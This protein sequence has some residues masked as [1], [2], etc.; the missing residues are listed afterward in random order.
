MPLVVETGAGVAG[1]DAYV[2]V[3][4]ADTYHADRSNATWAAAT[5]PEKEA[6]IRV[7]TQYIDGAYYAR[8]KGS[9]IN[10]LQARQWPRWGVQLEHTR[11][12]SSAQYDGGFLPGLFP[13]NIIPEQLKQAVCELAL[14]A[15]SG[16]LAADLKRGGRVASV[17][18]GP[19]ETSYEAGAPAA[20]VYQTVDQLLAP[21]IA[22][23][24]QTSLVRG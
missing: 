21:F 18:V 3:A 12:V 23:A 9:I 7:A 11:S 5:Q 13:S 20:T 15:L 22:S 17:K 2:E 24:Q 6:A 16:P 4:F 10:V 14:R 8:W 1:A 19:I